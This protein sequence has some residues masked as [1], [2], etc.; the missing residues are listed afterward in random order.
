L[1]TNYGQAVDLGAAFVRYTD[2]KGVRSDVRITL[3]RYTKGGPQ[4][5]FSPVDEGLPVRYRYVYFDERIDGDKRFKRY[6]TQVIDLTTGRIAASHTVI[7]YAWT[8]SSRVILSAPTGEQCG[9]GAEEE[10]FVETVRTKGV[11]K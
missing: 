4:Y 1:G 10:S 2:E 11:S 8:P 7:V 3:P 6:V 9:S 5:S